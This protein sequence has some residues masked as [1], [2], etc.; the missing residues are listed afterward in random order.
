[1]VSVWPDP[2]VQGCLSMIYGCLSS[3][4]KAP[5]DKGSAILD[6]IY[7]TTDNQQS[8]IKLYRLLKQA[9]GAFPMRALI[10]RITPCAERRIWFTFGLFKRNLGHR[11]VIQL[12]CFLSV[13]G[14]K[15]CESRVQ[16]R[17]K[18]SPVQW[19]SRILGKWKRERKAGTGTSTRTHKIRCK[20]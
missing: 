17:V 14:K 13:H 10:N 16:S 8:I 12:D 15:S 7:T 18:S 3:I 2:F 1:M 6:Q 11:P 9:I 4:I 20:S 19:A 5:C